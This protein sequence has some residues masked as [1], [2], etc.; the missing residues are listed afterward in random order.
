[1]V[2]LLG[3]LV[4]DAGASGF[5]LLEESGKL[6]GTSYAGTAAL[7]ED[8]S[9]VYY[10]PAGMARIKDW[11]FAQSGYL[12]SLQSEL[13]NATAT[14]FG[15][16]VFGKNGATSAD[17]STL[18]PVGATMFAKRLSDDIVVGFA[19]TVPFGL[20]TQYGNASIARFIATKSRL[21]T[22]N[23]SPSISYQLVDG[24]SI[25][26]G[27]DAVHADVALNQ[28]VQLPGQDELNV[29]LY[30]TDWTFGWNAGALWQID[31]SSRIGLAYRSKLT[32]GLN[33]TAQVTPNPLIAANQN[34]NTTTTFPDTWV[35]SGVT[36]VA[37]RWQLLGDL[38]WVHW[39][40]LQNVD[41]KF[42]SKGSSHGQPVL[43]EQN[44]PFGFRDVFRGALGTQYAYDD[45]WTF[46]GGAAFDQS[47]V[48]DSNRTARLPDANRVLLSVGVGYR[49][50]KEMSIDLAYTHIFFPWTSTINQT[51]T[52]TT[53]TGSYDSSA[54]LVGIQFT[55][56]FDEGIPLFGTTI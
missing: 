55:F 31:D 8:A 46:R 27:F 25:G 40:V 53:L 41:V 6:Q 10:N 37:P 16:P 56:T 17:L 28:K 18:S 9:T 38:Q 23:L 7:A 42:E 33:G 19:F 54:N 29:R 21:T 49:L 30:A 50:L 24:L 26:A 32:F 5:F 14:N 4:R 35:L 44:L 51:G 48:T 1:V 22:Y 52:G 20:T 45:T 3:A 2:A 39:S 43:P 36:N 11:S 47:P 12:V 15:Q 13:Q 34:A